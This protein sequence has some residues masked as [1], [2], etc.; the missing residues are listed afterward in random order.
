MGETPLATP[1]LLAWARWQPSR[2]TLQLTACVEHPGLPS[3]AAGSPVRP[4]HPPHCAAALGDV[5]RAELARKLALAIVRHPPG[6]YQSQEL[7]NVVWAMGT[8]GVLCEEALDQL[9]EGVSA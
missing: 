4:Q 8:M 5:D 7:S 6:E 9:L 1:K 2:C 3:R